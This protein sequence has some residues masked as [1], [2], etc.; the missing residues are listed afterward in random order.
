ME[1]TLD[2]F[3]SSWKKDF[4][5]SESGECDASFFLGS[6]ESVGKFF[7][8]KFTILMNQN[9]GCRFGG[10]PAKL[11][12]G[13]TITVENGCFVEVVGGVVFFTSTDCDTSTDDGIVSHFTI[14]TWQISSIKGGRLTWLA[15]PVNG[16]C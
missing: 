15:D 11:I 8:G 10:I 6:P 14:E 5:M 12:A 7:G 13:K 16:Q 2:V 3:C 4:T 1:G 9:P